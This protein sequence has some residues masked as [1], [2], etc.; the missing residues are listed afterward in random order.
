MIKGNLPKD[1]RERDL[2]K[3]FKHFGRVRDVLVKTGY[4][5]VEFDEHRSA[6]KDFH[7]F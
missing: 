4:G 3:E 6:L 1:C 5:F 2:E 7:Y